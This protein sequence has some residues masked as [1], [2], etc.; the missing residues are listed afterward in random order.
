MEN[1]KQ[2]KLSLQDIITCI[3]FI[4]LEIFFIVSTQAR[5]EEIQNWKPVGPKS[6]QYFAIK[7][8]ELFVENLIIPIY[9]IKYFIQRN[10][11]KKI[12]KNI[13]LNNSEILKKDIY[14]LLDDKEGAIINAIIFYNIVIDILWKILISLNIN[15]MSSVDY[16]LQCLFNVFPFIVF[17][18]SI[19]KYFRI[20][21]EIEK[22]KRNILKIQDMEKLKELNK[23]ISDR[24]KFFYKD[25]IIN[26]IYIII[27][28]F[29]ILGM[30]DILFMY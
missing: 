15:M 2:M 20:K 10:K 9:I 21:N 22:Y 12:R 19:F 5:L 11:I 13:L 23:L 6:V 3:I 16:A 1:K 8:I 7:V 25:F 30:L 24:K 4:I 17:I 18:I 26:I 27:L 14:K 29:S 28:R